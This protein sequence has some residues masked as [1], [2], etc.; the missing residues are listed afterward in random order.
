MFNALDRVDKIPWVILIPFKIA[1]VGCE[2]SLTTG[3]FDSTSCDYII[4]S[5]RATYPYRK[6]TFRSPRSVRRLLIF[7][8]FSIPLIYLLHCLSQTGLWIQDNLI[9]KY[10]PIE[11]VPVPTE[12]LVSGMKDCPPLRPGNVKVLWGFWLQ[13]Y[14]NLQHTIIIKFCL[15]KGLSVSDMKF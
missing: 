11:H 1:K 5:M 12:L 10:G 2:I 15:S 14:V 8:T 13:G 9:T 7:V 4:H 3:D 6:P